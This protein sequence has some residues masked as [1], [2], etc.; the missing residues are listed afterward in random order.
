MGKRGLVAIE[1]IVTHAEMT[2]NDAA[3]RR[4]LELARELT[5]LDPNGLRTWKRVGDLAW[6]VGDEDG[7]RSAYERALEL[8]EA[9]ELDPLKRLNDRERTE[10]E[11]RLGG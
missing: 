8:D 4:A 11:T 5:T 3:R 10:I 1:T 9:Y 6:S 2:G 7:M